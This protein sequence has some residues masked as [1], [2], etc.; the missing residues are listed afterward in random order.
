MTS[1]SLFPVLKKKKRKERKEQQQQQKEAM[2]HFPAE[3]IFPQHLPV[4][5]IKL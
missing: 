5:E 4:L 1:P 2:C 3:N